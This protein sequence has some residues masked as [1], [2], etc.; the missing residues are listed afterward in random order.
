MNLS[1]AGTIA[2]LALLLTLPAAIGAPAAHADTRTATVVDGVDAGFTFDIAQ[3]QVATD[4]DAGAMTA[5]ISLHAP[6]PATIPTLSH[7]AVLWSRDA[8]AGAGCFGSGSGKVGDT[9]VSI[10]STNGTE[11]QATVNVSFRAN[12]PTIPVSLNAQ[13]TQMTVSISDE[14][15]KQS[16]HRCLTGH[17]SGRAYDPSQPGGGSQIDSFGPAWFDGQAPPAAAPLPGG[18]AA[19]APCTDPALKMGGATR[20]AHKSTGLISVE[21]SVIGG[22]YSDVTLVM[23]DTGTSTAFFKHTFNGGELA[24][25]RDFETLQ[26][27]IDLDPERRPAIVVLSWKQ[28]DLDSESTCVLTQRVA[29]YRGRKP[30]FYARGGGVGQIVPR[31]QRCWETRGDRSVVTVTA[32][33]RRARFTRT[34][35]CLRFKGAGRVIGGMR[36]SSNEYG[37]VDFS[38]LGRGRATVRV[39]VNGATVLKRTVISRIRSRP[40]RRVFDSTDAFFNYCIKGNRELFSYQ[41]RLYCI[42]PG[43]YSEAVLFR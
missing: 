10:S 36:V 14:L 8:D 30:A 7:T 25:L 43:S 20:V 18:P 13:R 22:D 23:A 2:R 31:G 27:F 9:Y 38:S 41:L 4:R 19:P 32:G 39:Q 37:G 21:D 15:L 16:N 26:F 17:S 11:L 34:D 1:R 33:G 40:D 12:Y 28:K 3:I 5:V 35:A 24:D 42:R 29:S 6:V